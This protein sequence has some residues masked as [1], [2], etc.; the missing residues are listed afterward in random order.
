MAASSTSSRLEPVQVG[1]PHVQQDEGE[2]AA[3]QPLQG[4]PAGAGFDEGVAE[5]LQDRFEGEQV[6]GLVVHQQDVH[7]LWGR[8]VLRVVEGFR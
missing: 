2:F 5:V 7:P 8:Q 6:G 4:L 3:G 1:H